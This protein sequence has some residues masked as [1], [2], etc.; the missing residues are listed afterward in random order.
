M[1]TWNFPL[2]IDKELQYYKIDNTIV[3]LYENFIKE[4]LRLNIKL[5]I[6]S[7]P[8]FNIKHSKDNSILIAERIAKKYNVKYFDHSNDTTFCN[9]NNLFADKEHLNI[10]GSRIFSNVIIDQINNSCKSK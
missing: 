6:V 4:C 10:S 9:H 2:E 7:S 5:Y 3:N 8:Y 1:N